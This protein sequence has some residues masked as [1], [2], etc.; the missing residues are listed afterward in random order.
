VRKKRALPLAFSVLVIASI[1]IMLIDRAI[2][3][4]LFAPLALNFDM[5]MPIVRYIIRLHMDT[6]FPFFG[7]G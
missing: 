2:T 5:I 3:S 7:S 1:A 6:V 4:Y